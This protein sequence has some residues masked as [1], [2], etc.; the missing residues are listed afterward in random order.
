[1]NDVFRRR[2]L[3]AVPMMLGVIA[4]AS[5]PASSAAGEPPSS[6]SPTSAHVS[7][8]DTGEDG[9]LV[10]SAAPPVFPFGATMAVIQGDPSVAGEVFTVR[11]R[12][13]DGYVLPAHW[14]PTDEFVSVVSGTFLVGLGDAFDESALLP[15]LEAGDF[16]LAPA[17]A[18][19]F[20]TARGQ[21]EVQV[22][23]VGPFELTYV[24][25]DDD[26]RN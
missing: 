5:P 16:V 21:T 19:H 25:P 6:S 8:H 18:N 12:F 2:Y 9:E 13:P 3:L 15:P 7:G 17:N 1:V 22:H 14:H 26:P 23:A 4:L 11:L 20:A 24:N 10:F